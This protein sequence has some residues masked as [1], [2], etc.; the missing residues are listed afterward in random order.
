MTRYRFKP[1]WDREIKLPLF[2]I[3]YHS[4]WTFLRANFVWLGRLPLNEGI[5]DGYPLRDRYLIAS[6]S[7]SVKTVLDRHRLAAYGNRHC[8]QAF[9][10]YTSMTLNP[11]N[12]QNFQFFTIS[13]CDWIF[14]EIIGDRPIQHAH[15]IK[16]MLWRSRLKAIC[17]QTILIFISFGVS[18]RGQAA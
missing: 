2:T 8:R 16:L 18:A 3:Y 12:V 9:W 11:N 1:G 4:V 6:S 7:C 14:A 5:K 10:G 13:R 15:E 17:F